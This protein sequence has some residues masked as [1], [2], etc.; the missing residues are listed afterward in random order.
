[1]H[2][3]NIASELTLDIAISSL[4]QH[5]LGGMR[6]VLRRPRPC[7]FCTFR[8]SHDFSTTAGLQARDFGRRP[9]RHN[10]GYG[11]DRGEDTGRSRRNEDVD[12]DG[13]RFSMN[14]EKRWELRDRQR[15]RENEVERRTDPMARMRFLEV[16]SNVKTPY[17]AF[18]Q[19]T[20]RPLRGGES[21]M[22]GGPDKPRTREKKGF[23]ESLHEA[24]DTLEQD[25]GKDWKAHET[26]KN[27]DM[28]NNKIKAEYDV[29]KYKILQSQKSD[30]NTKTKA[31]DLNAHYLRLKKIFKTTDFMGFNLEVKYAFYGYLVSPNFTKKDLEYQTSLA[32]LRFPSEWFPATRCWYRDIHLHVG[33]TNSGKTYHALKR[34]E[35]AE[36]GLYAGPLR[37]LAHEVYMRLNAR[38][39]R[40]NLITGDDRRIPVGHDTT[41]AEMSSCTVE[42]IPLNTVLDV[43]VIDEIQMIGSEDRGWAWTQAVL[44]VKAREL[45]LC[46]EER[47]VPIIKELTALCGDRLHIHR[48]E[49]LSPLKMAEESLDGNLRNLQKGDCIVA[50]SIV[51]IHGLRQIIEKTLKCKVA[52]IYGSLPPETR[53]QQAQLFNDPDSGYDILVASNAIGMG[54]NL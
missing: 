21:S 54:L 26:F 17:R 3:N 53:A 18:G 14:R 42:M 10:N 13:F 12:E 8:H 20:K 15:Q 16:Q 30:T 22:R 4:R 36:T 34:L 2:I 50:F 28:D 41:D 44:G 37:L 6:P 23:D 24:L 9:P 33:P 32:N 49:R 19:G 45:H 43:A 39:K 51:E 46:G 40:C 52:I 31:A 48:Y 5:I 47:V 7:I 25:A 27:L 11:S 29:F 38:G 35:E 1:M